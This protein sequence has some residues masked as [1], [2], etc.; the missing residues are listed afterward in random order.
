VLG[1]ESREV[2]ARVVDAFCRITLPQDPPV[3]LEYITA[4]HGG[5]RGGQTR[6]PG[7]IF[8][9]WRKLLSEFGDV[10]LTVAG[11]TSVPKLIPFA[12]LSI[13][14]KLW[15]NS[16]ISLAPEQAT[17]LLAMWH[18]RDGNNRIERTTAYQEINMRFAAHDLQ[19]LSMARLRD[20]LERAC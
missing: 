15:S 3:P 4:D 5:S 6:K 20:P 12:A 19:P 16:A 11:A 2:A 1:S 8:L 9:N 18:R 7:N 17:A 13:W 14:N 10:V